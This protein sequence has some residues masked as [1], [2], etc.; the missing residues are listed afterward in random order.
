MDTSPLLSE[1]SKRAQRRARK[2]PDEARQ[3]DVINFDAAVAEG[4]QIVAAGESNAW[5]LAEIAYQ[6]EPRYGDKTLT[7][8]A[9]AIGGI[10]ACTLE[11]RRYVYRKWKE[12]I[13]AAPPESFAV[14]QELSP[15]PELAAQIIKAKPSV[16]SR[17]A[18]KRV[19]EWKERKQ[20]ADPNFA[21]EQMK[22][23]FDDLLT[24][25]SKVVADAGFINSLDAKERQ[26]LKKA[27]TMPSVLDELLEG[28][29]A[30]KTMYEALK[31]L[32][33]EPA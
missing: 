3:P 27:I 5:R 25:T 14:A 2:Q 10:A 7:K 21:Y 32:V 18:R 16:T 1:T 31:R 12:E 13:P 28:E 4:K 30:F 20:Q 8:L 19:Q 11:R 26:L 9:K 33:D 6:V 29:R 17:E 24:R 22:K 23:R 15:Y